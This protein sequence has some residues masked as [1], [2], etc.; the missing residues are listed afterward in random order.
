MPSIYRPRWLRSSPLWQNVHR[1][2]P[3]FLAEYEDRYAPWELPELTMGK[4]RI[5]VLDAEPG[6]DDGMP[7][8]CAEEQG[9]GPARGETPIFPSGTWACGGALPRR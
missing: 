5:L 2:W 6:P 4:G 7:V 8:Y 9:A 1:A 3:T